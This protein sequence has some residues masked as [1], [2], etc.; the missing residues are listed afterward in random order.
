LIY[1]AFSVYLIGIVFAAMGVYRLW[2]GMVKPSR[3]NWA[4][5][6]GT[7]VAEMAYIFGCLITGGEIRR[8][9]LMDSSTRPSRAS[10][11]SNKNSSAEP[12]T[13]ASPKLKH[14]GPIIAALISLIA[15]GAGIIITHTLLGKPVIEKFITQSDT[16]NLIERLKHLPGST[17]QFWDQFSAQLTLLHNMASTWWELDWLNWRVI[18]FVYLTTCLTIRLAPVR[19]SLRA[20][21]AAVL[22]AAGI[23]ALL[24]LAWKGF[25]TIIEQ[26]WPLIIYLWSSLLFLLWVS[27]MIRGGIGLIAALAGKDLSTTISSH[28]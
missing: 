20:T 10:R 18:L 25:E 2:A 14:L 12:T 19:R 17:A 1:G 8:A 23:I 22:L 24:G 9:K 5:L 7:I 28:K 11:H 16:A 13:E 4:L 21:L 3:V 6:P 26:L 27:L 15:C